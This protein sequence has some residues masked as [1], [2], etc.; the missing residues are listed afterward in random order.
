M[1]PQIDITPFL[2]V[3]E[4]ALRAAYCM[5]VGIVFGAAVAMLGVLLVGDK[6]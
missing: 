2:Q 5:I 6:E 3:V 1:I 4:L